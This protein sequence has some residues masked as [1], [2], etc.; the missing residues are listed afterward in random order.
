MKQ[1]FTLL[2]ILL[3]F[4]TYG[5][6]RYH[7][8]ETTLSLEEYEYGFVYLKKDSVLVTGIIYSIY[9][10]D[11]IKMEHNYK[12][13]V[14]SGL[15]R[16]WYKNGQL[17]YKAIYSNNEPVGIEKS[18]HKNGQLQSE[19]NYPFYREWYK[20]G[21]LKLEMNSGSELKGNSKNCWDKKGN[22]I[23]CK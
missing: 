17:K 4:S 23:E 14:L 15:F 12:K 13:G 2:L 9:K 7:I 16:N 1:L 8:N 21:Q 3:L 18:W 5:Q 10:N 22:E 20:N 6:N 11:K 19:D